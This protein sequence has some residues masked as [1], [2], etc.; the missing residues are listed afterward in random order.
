[1]TSLVGVVSPVNWRCA[2]DF[3]LERA[4]R[5]SDTQPCSKLLLVSSQ[6][7][8][9]GSTVIL[10]QY[11]LNSGTRLC[12][13]ADSGSCK[14][15]SVTSFKMWHV[16]TLNY[17]ILVQG[18]INLSWHI[19]QMKCCNWVCIYVVVLSVRMSAV[20]SFCPSRCV[21]HSQPRHPL[22]QRLLMAVS[23]PLR[24]FFFLFFSN[25]VVQSYQTQGS[26]STLFC[27][28]WF[29]VVLFAIYFIHVQKY[30]NMLN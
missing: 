19:F 6:T 4:V 18:N 3:K 8:H 29:V 17:I 22:Q 24:S 9:S 10:L 14:Q 11:V 21:C 16:S 28:F 20:S 26:N 13:F 2:T 15:K 5:C 30:R 23:L 1:M 27:I 12:S 7:S 25:P